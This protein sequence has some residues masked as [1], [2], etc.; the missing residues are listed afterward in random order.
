VT[1]LLLAVICVSAQP[2]LDG[3]RRSE[4]LLSLADQA[5]RQSD[6]PLALEAYQRALDAKLIT[7]DTLCLLMARV[8]MYKGRLDSAFAYNSAFRA[9]AG[10]PL[11][12]RQ[13]EQRYAVY[14]L[15]GWREELDAIADSLNQ[16]REKHR[17]SRFVNGLVPQVSLTTTAGAR[18]EA[19]RGAAAPF[20]NGLAQSQL[21]RFGPKAIYGLKAKL[22]W[23]MPTTL[24]RFG[25]ALQGSAA[26]HYRTNPSPSKAGFL[27]TLIK[28]S[29]KSLQLSLLSENILGLLSVRADLRTSQLYLGTRSDYLS[30]SLYHFSLGSRMS[31]YVGLEYATRL[32]APGQSL[33]GMLY[34]DPTMVGQ[35]GLVVSM[36][37]SLQRARALAYST[38]FEASAI[39]DSLVGQGSRCR[40]LVTEGL[41]NVGSA[42]DRGT[43]FLT[44]ADP[45]LGN[46]DPSRTFG[47]TQPQNFL[48]LSTDL[49]YRSRVTSRLSLELGAGWQMDYYLQNTRWTTLTASPQNIA[50]RA[51]QNEV[52]LLYDRQTDAYY[53]HGSNGDNDPAFTYHEK[54]RIDQI[55]SVFGQLEL[56]TRAGTINLKGIVEKTYSRLRK[57]LPLA[58]DDLSVRVTATW[59]ARLPHKA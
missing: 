51:E 33:T 53:W 38:A 10:T 13:L 26:K 5:F 21:E 2:L 36:M 57:D 43:I 24:A 16:E 8:Y 35:R 54:R 4:S 23:Y 19:E 40:L 1:L 30:A 56:T 29:E 55:P 42:E 15:L 18:Y 22:A 34:L 25:V 37:G 41:E 46:L 3:E 32:N 20:E 31:R 45:S 49:S 47:V 52:T 48:T 39:D 6:W 7:A 9:K 17:L 27:D 50:D 14:N 12:M 11:R 28:R 59:F 58:V 44:Y